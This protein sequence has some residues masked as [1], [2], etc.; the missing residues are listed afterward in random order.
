MRKLLIFSIL[1]CI[2]FVVGCTMTP[3]TNTAKFIVSFDKE[4]TGDYKALM[5]A[6][7]R[8]V[9]SAYNIKIVYSA[10]ED[11]ADDKPFRR[12]P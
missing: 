12:M 4:F 6:H 3:P 1:I 10:W 8:Y 5:Q 2:S 9:E 7:Q 11:E